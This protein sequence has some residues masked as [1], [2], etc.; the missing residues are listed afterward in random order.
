MLYWLKGI[1]D[2]ACNRILMKNLEGAMLLRLN[3]MLG[4]SKNGSIVTR[5]LG[6]PSKLKL[7]SV[8]KF[9]YL[10]EGGSLSDRLTFYQVNINYGP[11]IPKGNFSLELIAK[12]QKA[13]G[14][15]G[16]EKVRKIFT[17]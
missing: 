10:F 14:G 5:V 8:S 6:V 4:R 9:A 15:R 11:K 12:S 16:Q 7:R 2:L 17:F 3:F 1:R 13:K